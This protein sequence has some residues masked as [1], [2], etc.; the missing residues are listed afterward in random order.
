MDTQQIKQKHLSWF[1]VKLD[2]NMNQLV[3]FSSKK[4]QI[5]RFPFSKVMRCPSHSNF[6]F[7]SVLQI[8]ISRQGQVSMH[9]DKQCGEKVSLDLTSPKIHHV[10]SVIN[11]EFNRQDLWSMTPSCQIWL[12]AWSLQEQTSCCMCLWGEPHPMWF[13]CVLML[14]FQVHVT[15]L[16]GQ[17]KGRGC[18]KEAHVSQQLL[19]K[20]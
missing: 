3:F 8:G 12:G 10:L 19:S 18:R 9:R 2:E 5:C 6:T 4:T 7:G 13:H 20:P 1:W 17:I 11:S 15:T 16:Y 14:M